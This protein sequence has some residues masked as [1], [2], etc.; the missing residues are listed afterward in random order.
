[1]NESKPIK[2]QKS[3]LTKESIRE[4]IYSKLYD[5]SD[6]LLDNECY[7]PKSITVSNEKVDL[8]LNENERKK[9]KNIIWYISHS[10]LWSES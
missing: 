5:S 6:Y 1:M 10:K 8:R 2:G 4:K 7:L 9:L 3:K